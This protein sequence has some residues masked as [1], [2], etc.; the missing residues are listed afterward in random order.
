MLVGVGEINYFVHLASLQIVVF[1]KLDYCASLNNLNQVR[2][3]PNFKVR[4]PRTL[5]QFGAPRPSTIAH[6]CCCPLCVC[7]LSRVTSSPWIF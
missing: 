6:Y 1:D 3:K 7:S 2:H 5:H 4:P